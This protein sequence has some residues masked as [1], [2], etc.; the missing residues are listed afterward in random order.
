VLRWGEE[1]EEEEEVGSEIERLV[2]LRSLATTCNRTTAAA[3]MSNIVPLT[4]LKEE[5]HATR[6]SQGLWLSKQ[7]AILSV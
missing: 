5:A 1:E 3:Y 6:L 7:A 4:V 2:S